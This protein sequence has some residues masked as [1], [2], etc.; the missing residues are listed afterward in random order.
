MCWTLRAVSRYFLYQGHMPD[1]SSAIPSIRA[2]RLTAPP[3]S[4]FAQHIEMVLSSCDKESALGLCDYA[5]L[6]LLSRLGLWAN[7]IALLRLD[8]INWH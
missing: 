4:L 8:E 1:L 3:E 2:W 7:E 5:A 6:M